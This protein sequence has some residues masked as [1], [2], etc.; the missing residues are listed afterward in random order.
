MPFD[1][2]RSGLALLDLYP[3]LSLGLGQAFNANCKVASIVSVTF[4]VTSDD[5]SALTLG[6]HSVSMRPGR[7]DSRLTSLVAPQGPQLEGTQYG[8]A[9][10]TLRFVDGGD[11]FGSDPFVEPYDGDYAPDGT[12]AEPVVGLPGFEGFD[13][14]IGQAP[15]GIWNL[16]FYF[17]LQEFVVQCAEIEMELELVTP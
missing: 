10:G 6:R 2:G 15:G 7:A 5:L 9:C 3:H 12:A 8:S 13:A 16:N 14:Q 17:G 1:A 4:W 11:E